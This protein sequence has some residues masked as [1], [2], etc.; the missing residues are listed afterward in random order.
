MTKTMVRPRETPARHARRPAGK[1]DASRVRLVIADN[2]MDNDPQTIHLGTVE[3]PAGM[4]AKA[5]EARVRE[6][7]PAW[8]ETP[9]R[10]LDFEFIGFL[11]KHGF[12]EVPDDTVY[13]TI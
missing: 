6:L 12:K 11:G 1:S 13:I 7:L 2:L 9:G 3:A 10:D 4:P 8:L 5:A